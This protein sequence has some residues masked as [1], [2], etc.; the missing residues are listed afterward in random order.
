VQSYILYLHGFNSSPQSHKAQVARQWLLQHSPQL[1]M[2]TPVL[3]ASPREAVEHLEANYFIDSDVR[4]MGIIGSSLGGYYALYLSVRYG[5]PAA[6]V[7]PAITPYRLLEDY[8]GSN[9]NF[10]TGEEYE[11]G[12]QHMA[13]LLALETKPP[14]QPQQ[15]LTLLQTGDK[16]LDYRE[17]VQ[18]FKYHPLWVQF[19][20][21]HAFEGFERTL[22]AIV[23]FFQRFAENRE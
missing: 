1:H 19:G 12:P 9:T 15:V 11:L 2:E 4:P 6:L 17:A 7:N 18:K 8:L 13:E 14:V 23:A 5:V 16:T 21:S 20:G 10:Y 22:P 3:A